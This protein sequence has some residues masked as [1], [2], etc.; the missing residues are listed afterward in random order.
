MGIF[1]DYLGEPHVITQGVSHWVLEVVPPRTVRWAM[2][3]AMEE[4]G[5]RVSVMQCEKDLI[6]ICWL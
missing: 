6:D 4:G 3:M 2:A 1:L 5:R